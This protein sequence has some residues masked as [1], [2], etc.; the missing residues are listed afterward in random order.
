MIKEK[1]EQ[2]NMGVERDLLLGLCNK[3]DNFKK[4]SKYVDEKD[5][6]CEE[7]RSLYKIIASMYS[8]ANFKSITQSSVEIYS[9]DKGM[10]SDDKDRILAFIEFGKMS[11]IDFD[12]TYSMFRKISGMT[13]LMREGKKYGGLENMFYNIYETSDNADQIRHQID[14][15]SKLCFKDYRTTTRV[16]DMSKGMEEYVRNRMFAND[17]RSVSFL[18][19]FF[20]LQQYSKGIHVGVTFWGSFSGA[21][22]TTTVIP[23]FSIPIL[24]SGQKLL[25][26]HNEQEEDEIRQLYLMAYIAMVKGDTKGIFR[27]NFNFEGR[28]K[29]T[30]EQFEYLCQ[31]AREFEER[32]KG[33]LEF[34]FTPRFTEDDIESLIEEYHRLGFDN[35]LLDTFKQ[36]DSTNGWEG[37]DNLAKKID[38]LSKDLGMKIIC[39]IQL[40]QHVSWRKYLTANCIGKAKS[41]KEVATSLYMF[42]WLRPEELPYIKYSKFQKD[43]TT[44]K[45]HWV[46]NDLPVDYVDK[47]GQ[48][49]PKNYIILFNDKQRKSD[50]GQVILYEVDLGR[51][52][53]EEIGVTTSIK[54]DDNGR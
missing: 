5:F 50:C 36:E 13:K 6:I 31:C 3:Y 23:I 45:Y 38:G 21:G 33:R 30:D 43:K 39:T 44:G 53:F 46:T 51:M 26:I 40:A 24:E 19:K 10:S 32:Y 1:I 4:V 49:R 34:V 28:N 27:Q 29:F 15:L 18:K 17:G 8:N 35:V 11:E 42:R 41:V 48:R 22:K 52:Y 37:M 47:Y 7:Y 14:Y 12:G 2:A 54:N 20:F 9:S 16:V 25:S